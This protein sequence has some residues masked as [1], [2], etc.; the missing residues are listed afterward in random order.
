[1]IYFIGLFV[2]WAILVIVAFVKLGKAY[3]DECVYSRTL[4]KTIEL[5]ADVMGTLKE[6]CNSSAESYLEMSAQLIAAKLKIEQ[7]EQEN[8]ELKNR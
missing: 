4:E 1:M 8:D 3:D 5:Q 6:E 7:L 2:I